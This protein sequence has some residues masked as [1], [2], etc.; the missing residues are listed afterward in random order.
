MIRRVLIL[1]V[2]E[3]LWIIM[4]SRAR[5]NLLQRQR[6]SASK[7]GKMLLFKKQGYQIWYFHNKDIFHQETF[8]PNFTTWDFPPKIFHFHSISFGVELCVNFAFLIED[9]RTMT[10]LHY[11]QGWRMAM[12]VIMRVETRNDWEWVRRKPENNDRSNIAK[13]ASP[14]Q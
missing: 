7:T 10:E 6:Q 9:V 12:F 2:G 11:G 3:S 5:S 4:Q 14:S 13:D 8:P 1:R